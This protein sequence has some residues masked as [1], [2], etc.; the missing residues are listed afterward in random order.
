MVLQ[1]EA[2]LSV[3]GDACRSAKQNSMAKRK[4]AKPNFP[5]IPIAYAGVE[6]TSEQLS[7]VQDLLDA[8]KSCLDFLAWTNGGIPRTPY[9]D[10]TNSRGRRRTSRID[11][12]FGFDCK[13]SPASIDQELD[14]T[15]AILKFRHWLPRWSIP[16]GFV[17]DDWFLITF[18][19]FDHREGQVWLKE[20]CHDVPDD[21]IDPNKR[22][23]HVAD[24]L[25]EFVAS[26][27]ADVDEP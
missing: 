21:K 18:N 6:L 3:S 5:D 8:P 19:V 22:I 20:W 4:T 14:I 11:Q 1:M 2:S 23:H 15:W 17:D 25:N 13:C 9:F 27:Y 24:S 16:L 10:W 12:L 7:S 26:W